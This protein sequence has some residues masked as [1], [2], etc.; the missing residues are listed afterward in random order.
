MNITQI[1]IFV[2]FL[3]PI[4]F[5]EHLFLFM[6]QNEHISQIAGLYCRMVA[7][8]MIFYAVGLSYANFAVLHGITHYTLL[9]NIISSGLHYVLTYILCYIYDFKMLGVAIATCLHFICRFF[10]PYFLVTRNSFFDESLIPFSD[11]DSWKGLG[12]MIS[13][14]FVSV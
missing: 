8:G 11:K 2:P 14:G 4:L 6:G 13:L 1:L 9:T 5:I 3:F 12:E 10:V 7:P